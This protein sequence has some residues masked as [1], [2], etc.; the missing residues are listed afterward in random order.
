M[1]LFDIGLPSLGQ[2]LVLHLLLRSTLQVRTGV[3]FLGIIAKT[4]VFFFFQ[5]QLF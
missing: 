4:K 3:Q 2:L 5:F 1:I